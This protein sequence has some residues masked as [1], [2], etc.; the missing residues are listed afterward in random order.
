MRLPVRGVAIAAFILWSCASAA[1]PILFVTQTPHSDD[2]TTCL[3]V[4]GNHRGGVGSAPRGGDLYIRYD[5]GTLRNLTLEAGFGTNSTNQIAV[6]EPSVHWSGTKVLFSMVVGGTIKDNYTPVYFQIYEV[7]GIGQG[8]TVTMTRIPQPE[9]YNN[10]SPLYG[11]DDRIL[12]TSDRPRNGD[13]RLYPQLD[14]YETAPT[15]TGIWSMRSDGTDLRLL[16]HAPSGDFRPVIDSFG[17]LVFTRWDHLQRDQQAD[18]DI[19]TIIEGGDISDGYGSITYESEE[20]DVFHTVAPGD[21]VF[22]EARSLF[23]PNETAHPVWNA[24][25]QHDEL[26]HSLN[27]FIPWAC[28]EDGSDLETLNHLGRH[29][30]MGYIPPARTGLEELYNFPNLRITS[31]LSGVEDPNNPGYF[32]GIDA[33]E[34][35]THASGQ[36]VAIAAPPAENADNISAVYIT[37]KDTRSYSGDG[38]TPNANQVGLFRDVMAM[39]DG[40]LWAAH[41][42]SPYADRPTAQDP[43]GNNPFPLSS[44]YNYRITKMVDGANGFKVPGPKL[45]PAGITDSVTYFD[46]NRYRTVT[47]SGPMWEVFPVEVRARQIPA[48]RHTPIPAIETAIL[49]EELGGQLGIDQLRDYLVRNDLALLVARDVTQRADKQQYYNLRVSW[50]GHQTA[51]PGSTPT[52]L[53]HMQFFEGRQLRGQFEGSRDGRRVLG[54]PMAGVDNPPADEGPSGSVRI[55]DDGSVAAFVPAR[56]A[57]SWQTTRPGGTAAVRER[58]WLTFQPGEIRSCTNCH[59]VN[60]EDIFNNPPASNPPE[61]LTGLLRWWKSVQNP[62]TSGWVLR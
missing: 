5:D 16:D 9:N 11:T 53:A 21:E 44:R 6:R 23:G 35:S 17:R 1:N 54:R 50:S 45:I 31:F 20:S 13:R 34:F 3:S 12:F 27:Q 18:A 46:N 57:L 58:Y 22:P 2:F 19:E 36:I 60:T 48:R 30:L 40:T 39:S 52:D 26:R 51:A 7:T 14:E 49:E 24:D 62:D 38:Q 15:V 59:G 37:H 28:N 55:A 4:F 25:H 29:E 43:G 42:S 33:P 47:Y 8:Q 56:R 41:S 61:A 32:Y 10:V